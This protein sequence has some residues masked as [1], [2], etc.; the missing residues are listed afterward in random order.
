MKYVLLLILSFN[1]SWSAESYEKN[2]SPQDL[3]IVSKVAGMCGIFRQMTVFQES[4]KMTGGD[5]FIVRFI[6]T[7]IA[8]LGW[9][10]ETFFKNCEMAG[11]TYDLYMNGF[12]QMEKEEKTNIK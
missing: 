3:M 4:T 6:H 8:R 10:E 2:A 1:I 12:E 7:E 9:T 11:S 5:E